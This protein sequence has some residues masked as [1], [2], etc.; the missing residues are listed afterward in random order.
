LLGAAEYLLASALRDLSRTIEAESVVTRAVAILG[1]AKSADDPLLLNAES[2]Q[3]ALYLAND[4]AA[5]AERLGLHLVEVCSKPGTVDSPWRL[6]I[7]KSVLGG[8]YSAQKKYADAERL[9]LDG[10]REVDGD[11]QAP[12]RRRSDALERMIQFYESTGNARE[13]AHWKAQRVARPDL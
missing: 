7:V 9:L 5:D 6:G 1:D 2:L 13:A 10:F 3:A 11:P 12:A 8:A 4:K